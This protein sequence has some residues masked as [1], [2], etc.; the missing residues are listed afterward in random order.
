MKQK[1]IR[2]KKKQRTPQNRKVQFRYFFIQLKKKNLSYTV[3]K[4]ENKPRILPTNT[5]YN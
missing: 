3:G 2:M 1:C 5:T 4:S